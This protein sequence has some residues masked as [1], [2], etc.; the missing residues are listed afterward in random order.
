MN[1]SQDWVEF[2]NNW[3]GSSR[4][5]SYTSEMTISLLNLILIDANYGII[6]II[7]H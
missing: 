5:T 7:S 3:L 2:W 6:S 4:I 1:I